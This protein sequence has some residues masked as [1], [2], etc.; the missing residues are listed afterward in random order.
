MSS[1]V[2][3][4]SGTRRR[5]DVQ[6]SSA[7]AGYTEASTAKDVVEREAEPSST[8]APSLATA[9]RPAP[10]KRE[11]QGSSLST[12]STEPIVTASGPFTHIL[13][14]AADTKSSTRKISVLKR[15]VN[16][17]TVSTASYATG[18]T[19]LNFQKREVTQSTFVSSSVTSPTT[20]RIVERYV[21]T[22][23]NS[24]A[25]GSKTTSATW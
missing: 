6:E 8:P 25:H 10:Q 13:M 9:S 23:V 5:R 12:E 17:I 24:T 1:T 2:T 22:T 4:T 19:T 16:D 7:F 3:S 18:T 15:Q 21:D 20:V 11:V 14:K